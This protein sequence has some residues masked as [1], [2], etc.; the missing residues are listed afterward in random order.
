L[1][2]GIQPEEADELSVQEG[3]TP[4]SSCYGCGP[5]NPEGLQLRSYRA[6]DGL[7]ARITLP[8]K[9]CAF[10]GIINGG[11]ISTLMVRRAARCTLPGRARRR[12]TAGATCAAVAGCAAHP[13]ARL[14]GALPCRT[15]M[16]TGLQR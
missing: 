12:G 7:V 6:P 4:N 14:L 16:A 9:Y 1:E 13:R 3:Y 10:P 5:C 2:E 11:I 8:A 15:A